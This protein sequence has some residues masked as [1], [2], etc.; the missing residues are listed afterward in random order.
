MNK[1]I[2]KQQEVKTTIQISQSHYSILGSLVRKLTSFL[3]EVD[4][5]MHV[6]VSQ[7]VIGITCGSITDRQTWL[8]MVMVFLLILEELI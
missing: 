8:P 6:M 2:S 4:P 3:T 7:L 5:I 1:P